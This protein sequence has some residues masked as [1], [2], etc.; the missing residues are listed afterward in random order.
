MT[1]VGGG[2]LGL[3]TARALLRR[4]AG[5]VTVLEK[6]P[7]VAAHQSGHNSG[8]L[9]AGLYYPPGSEKATLCTTGRRALIAFCRENGIAHERCGKLVVATRNDQRPWLD[10]LEQRACANGLEGVERLGPDG[11]RDREPEVA[12]VCGLWVPM[13]GIV[14]YPAVARALARDVA[15]RGGDV[16]CGEGLVGARQDGDGIVL[17]TGTSEHRTRFAVNCAGLQSDRVAQLFGSRPD[18]RIVPFRGD[19]AELAPERRSLVRNLIYPV[20]DPRFPFLGVHLTRTIDGRVETGPNAV[21]ALAREGYRR[22]AVGTRD[23]WDTLRYP[24][25][26][27]FAARHAR[28]GLGELLRGFSSRRFVRDLQA[29]VPAVRKG[30]LRP[31]GCGIR[32]QALDV[33][34]RLVDDFR[35]TEGP[36]SLHVLNAPSPAATACLA[37]GEV[38]AQR[39]SATTS[40]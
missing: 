2:L 38:I 21:L 26:W 7:E 28:T 9:H 32:A 5:H 30:D 37:I 31:A 14:D 4:D 24:G 12:G 18:V 8:V 3:A 23:A 33:R 19:Y 36:R 16:R 29:L 25:W 40:R 20:P 1:V 13:T 17:R 6:E 11:L 27:R 15:T 34:G 22:G 39:V 35:F 10:R